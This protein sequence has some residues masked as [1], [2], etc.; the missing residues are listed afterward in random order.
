MFR[1]LRRHKKIKPT[2][3]SVDENSSAEEKI[4]PEDKKRAFLRLAGMAGLGTLAALVIPK[5]ADALV[6]GSTPSSS[7]VGVKNVSNVSINPAT[8]ETLLGIKTASDKLLFDVSGN[9][10]T[11]AT[12][13]V[14]TVSLKNISGIT[15]NPVTEETLQKVATDESVLLLRRLVKI[16]ESNATVDAS[17]RQRVVI[18]TMPTTTV[19][20]TVTVG[21]ITSLGQFAGVDARFLLIDTARNAYA[22]GIRN[23]LNFS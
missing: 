15:I 22:N 8:E 19:T 10:K 5:R 17:N 9:L 3:S 11:V 13:G 6:F 12:G 4:S 21:S 18:E 20:G 7:V 1:F 16:M 14:E 23:N 2:F